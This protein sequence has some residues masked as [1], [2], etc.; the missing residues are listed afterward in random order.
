M[1]PSDALGVV[2]NCRDAVMGAVFHCALEYSQPDGN[3]HTEELHE[4]VVGNVGS[5]DQAERILTIKGDS[6]P[7]LLEEIDL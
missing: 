2:T 5:I 6:G 4:D 7:C 3:K 1:H